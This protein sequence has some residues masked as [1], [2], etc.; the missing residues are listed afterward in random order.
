MGTCSIDDKWHGPMSMAY[1]L[2]LNSN[3]KLF[4]VQL[5]LGC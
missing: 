3:D 1:H 4:L 2:L 5:H